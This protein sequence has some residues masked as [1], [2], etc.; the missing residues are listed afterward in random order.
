MEVNKGPS[1]RDRGIGKGRSN[2]LARVPFSDGSEGGT[3]GRESSES[4]LLKRRRWS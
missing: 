4:G 2:I 1:A 3:N